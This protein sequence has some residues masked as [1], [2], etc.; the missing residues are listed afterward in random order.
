MPNNMARPKPTSPIAPGSGTKTRTK[1]TTVGP[2]PLG[3]P[4]VVVDP[5]RFTCTWPANPV[6]APWLVKIG[7][8]AESYKPNPNVLPAVDVPFGVSSAGPLKLSR[9]VKEF[10]KVKLWNNSCSGVL[11]TMVKVVESVPVTLPAV[12]GAPLI[13]PPEKLLSTAVADWELELPGLN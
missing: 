7:F 5:F 2:V 11:L 1:L 6:P 10:P 4:A 3:N 8:C 12:D 13:V 9:N